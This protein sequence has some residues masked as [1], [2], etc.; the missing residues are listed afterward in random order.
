MN[1]VQQWFGPAFDALDPLIQ[2][3]H[4]HGGVLEGEVTLFVGRG[5]LGLV[6]KRL[7]AKLGIPLQKPRLQLRV[8]MHT[9]EGQLY[10]GRCFDGQSQMMSIFE[11]IGSW[12]TGHWME[13]TGG[14]CMAL[15]VDIQNGGWY[16]RPIKAWLFGI[17]I[18]LQLLPRV[19]A[20]KRIEQG[21]YYFYVGFSIPWL[22]TVLSYSGTLVAK[23]NAPITAGVSTC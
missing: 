10:W 15:Q 18:P 2:K 20:Y 16:W 21:R 5:L 7:A 19:T 9:K 1:V 11:P 12:P 6:G 13:R 8:G 14:I 4:T 22:G 23:I 3:L 17:R